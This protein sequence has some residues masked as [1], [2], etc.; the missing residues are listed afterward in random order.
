MHLVG[1][2]HT[3][4][5]DARYT[6]RHIN[7]MQYDA[8]YTQRH[9][10]TLQYDARYTQR[11]INQEEIHSYYFCHSRIAV[12]ISLSQRI[13]DPVSGNTVRDYET[14]KKEIPLD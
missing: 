1:H 10:N 8:R 7:T 13:L 14:A 4:Q 3:L 6:Q 5:Y 2:L 12:T 9:I 11:Q